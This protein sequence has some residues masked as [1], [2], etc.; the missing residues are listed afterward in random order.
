MMEGTSGMM[1][2]GMSF[3]WLL[4]VLVLVLGAAALVK[5]LFF[6]GGK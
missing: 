6:G 2:W 4:A 5:Y 1:M 3:V